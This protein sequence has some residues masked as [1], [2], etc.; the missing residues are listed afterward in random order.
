MLA[1]V[2]EHSQVVSLGYEVGQLQHEREH[3]LQR[4]RALLL[5]SAS[6]ASLERIERLANERLGLVSAKPGQIQ[7]V[8]MEPDKD[9]AGEAPAAEPAKDA[10]LARAEPSP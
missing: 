8:K 10:H 9:V 1:A 2:W 4:H 6:L 7:L 5:E 3:E